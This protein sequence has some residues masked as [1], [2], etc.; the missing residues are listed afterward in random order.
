[1]KNYIQDGDTI[2]V[3]APSAVVSGDF[4]QVG[5]VRGI[6]VTSV[7]SGASVEL[8][9]TGVFTIPKLGSEAFATVGLPVYCVLASDGVKTVTTASTTANVLV[10]V[11]LATSAAS[12]GSLLVKLMPSASNQTATAVT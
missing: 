7:A 3:V 9:T 5:R 2:T 4:V 1:M 8:K 11:N 10:G 12:P 6:A